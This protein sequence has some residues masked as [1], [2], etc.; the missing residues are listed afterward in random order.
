MRLKRNAYSSL[1]LCA[2]KGFL[3]CW[4][5]FNIQERMGIDSAFSVIQGVALLINSMW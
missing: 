3:E 5:K 2:E 4:R 1:K